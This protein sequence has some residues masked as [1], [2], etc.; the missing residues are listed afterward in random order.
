LKFG[1]S[2]HETPDIPSDALLARL[3]IYHID[4]VIEDVENELKLTEDFCGILDNNS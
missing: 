4:K 3:Q 2:G 1:F